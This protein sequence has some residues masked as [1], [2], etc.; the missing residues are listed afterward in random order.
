[1]KNNKSYTVDEVLLFM[2]SYCTYQER[3]HAEVTQKLF[4]YGMITEA[5]EK[6]I[7]HLL[8]NNF[9]NEERFA[10]SYV[11]GKFNIKHW[12]RNKIKAGLHQRKISDY[13]IKSGLKEIDEIDYTKILG[14]EM[15][16]KLASLSE[17]NPWKRKKKVVDFL[18][19]KGFEYHFIEQQWNEKDQN[20]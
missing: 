13:N 14:I 10:K 7:I 20:S 12:G 9:L 6:I 4:E 2:E 17:K 1:M 18:L 8:S 5:Q 11:R 3:C 15:Q 19:Q 16:K